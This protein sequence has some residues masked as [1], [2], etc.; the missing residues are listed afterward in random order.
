MFFIF[1]GPACLLNLSIPNS[2]RITYAQT[3]P[4]FHAPP[5]IWQHSFSIHL[6]SRTMESLRLEAIDYVA[7]T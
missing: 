7:S 6:V 5:F 1:A 4:I 3:W 2:L